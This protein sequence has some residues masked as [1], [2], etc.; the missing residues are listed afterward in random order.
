MFS[1]AFEVKKTSKSCRPLFK[2]EWSHMFKH[3]SWCRKGLT[4]SCDAKLTEAIQT[5]K[6]KKVTTFS[7][8]KHRYENPSFESELANE[9]FIYVIKQ[10]HLYKCYTAAKHPKHN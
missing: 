1:R 7:K 6:P 9:P 3:L 5:M 4:I 8:V 2:T 10:Q